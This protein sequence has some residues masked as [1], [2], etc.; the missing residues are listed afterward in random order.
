MGWPKIDRPIL[1]WR[2]SA[3]TVPPITGLEQIRVGAEGSATFY[4]AAVLP[5][6]DS[7]VGAASLLVQPLGA[8]GADLLSVWAI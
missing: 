3:T 2:K 5:T 6:L 1:N 4:T 8:C 7:H